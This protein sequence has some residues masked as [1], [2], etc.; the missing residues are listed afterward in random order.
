MFTA[1][2][3]NGNPRTGTKGIIGR[4]DA[5]ANCNVLLEISDYEG[6]GLSFNTIGSLVSPFGVVKRERVVVGQFV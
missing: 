3:T 4:T 2:R 6:D 1:Q 5:G